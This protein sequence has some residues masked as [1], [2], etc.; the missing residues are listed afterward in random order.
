MNLSTII[1]K[2]ILINNLRQ[3]W[4]DTSVTRYVYTEKRMFFTYK[5]KDDKHLYMGN[6]LTF[7]ILGSKVIPK[8]TFK[9]FFTLNNMHHIADIK[10]NLV[11]YSLLSKN[12]F[13]MIFQSDIFIL[14]TSGMFI[15]KRYL[16]DSLF[17][18][19]VMTIII[20]LSHST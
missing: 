13:K 8:M 20:L 16:C 17:K 10:Q 1:S 3:Q 12:G 15:E 19:N 9:K 18:M 14:I 7:K 4:V 6:S 5:K 2:V 11:F